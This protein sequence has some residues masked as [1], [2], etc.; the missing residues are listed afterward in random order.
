METSAHNVVRM[1][2]LSSEA[3][4]A[5]FVALEMR[6]A[7][8]IEGQ[9]AVSEFDDVR[10][11]RAT[12]R[13]GSYEIQR[14]GWHIAASGS[15]HCFVCLPLGGDIRLKQ[16]GN[17]C[18]LRPFDLGLVDT[19]R[20]YTVGIPAGADALWIRIDSSR[21][22]WRL[23]GAPE[24][25]ARRIDGGDGA[26]HVA[27]SFIRSVTSQADRLS[28]QTRTTLVPMMADLLVEAAAGLCDAVQPPSSFR[29][30][31]QRTLERARVYIDRHLHDE[32]LDPD[33]I[34]GAVGISARYLG[35]LFAAEGMTTM[36]WV[37]RRRLDDCR[38]KLE[39]EVWRPGLITDLALSS[40]FTNVSSFNRAFKAAF[41][42]TPRESMVPAL[43]HRLM[44]N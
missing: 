13:G 30:S 44:Q 14:H 24:I 42:R 1:R 8:A 23:P 10:I 21:L 5:I 2:G 9:Y 37:S 22:D 6:N 39:S 19:R 31:S 33:Q 20:E 34:S 4:S 3:M 7:S 26:G 28:Q 36:G 32:D 40:G 25:F 35:Q 18:V 43:Q 16:D 41:G 12:S 29:T 17:M 15:S 11:I 38:R 27:S